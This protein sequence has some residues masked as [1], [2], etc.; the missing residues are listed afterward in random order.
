MTCGVS[1]CLKNK[2]RRSQQRSVA[3][4]KHAEKEGMSIKGGVASVFGKTR[5]QG[6]EVEMFYSVERAADQ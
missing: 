4:R 1:S 5:P 2:Q 3:G 6:L